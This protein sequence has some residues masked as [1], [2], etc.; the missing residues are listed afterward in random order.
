V[1]VGLEPGEVFVHRNVA[2]VVVHSDLNCLSVIQFAVEVLEVR[3]VIVCGH[4]GCGGVR[5]AVG[6]RQHG[7][8]DNWLR[9]IQ[10]VYRDHEGEL[11]AIADPEARLDRLTERHVERQVAHVATTTIVQNAW[12]RGHPVKVSGWIYSI[13]DGLLRDLGV[14]VAGPEQIPEIYRMGG[15][16]DR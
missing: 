6:R 2:N 1:I 4:Y 12:A 7:L 11:E 8:I 13:G 14:T 9:A 3:H 10:D 15:P 5:A 16:G